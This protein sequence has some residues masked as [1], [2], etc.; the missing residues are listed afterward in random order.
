MA[1]MGEVLTREVATIRWRLKKLVSV[2]VLNN[3]IMEVE[4]WKAWPKVETVNC[5]TSTFSCKDECS[6]RPENKYT[7]ASLQF[8]ENLRGK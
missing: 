1:A 7:E 5:H 3:D 8:A 6:T 2:F 4:A